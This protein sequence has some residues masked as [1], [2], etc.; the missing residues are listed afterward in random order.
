MRRRHKHEYK[1]E[2]TMFRMVMDNFKSSKIYRGAGSG[3]VNISTRSKGEQ[4]ITTKQEEP[5]VVSD[6]P[7][8]WSRRRVKMGT[9]ERV[10]VVTSK[11]LRITSQAALDIYTRLQQ[12]PNLRLDWQDMVVFS[13]GTRFEPDDPVVLEILSDREKDK[14]TCRNLLRTP[15][16]DSEAPSPGPSIWVRKEIFKSEVLLYNS[17]IIVSSV[18][19]DF[20]SQ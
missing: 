3:K 18:N 5:V 10:E 20:E 4:D 15:P 13:K 16:T 1:D 11:G 12:M 19:F 6:L 2:S 9:E 14:D 7:S 17:N 8:G